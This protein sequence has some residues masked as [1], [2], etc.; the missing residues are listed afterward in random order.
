MATACAANLTRCHLHH[1][2]GGEFHRHG[3][4]DGAAFVAGCVT[5]IAADLDNE[6]AAAIRSG[7]H[8]V[9]DDGKALFIGG[10][11][12]IISRSAE[13]TRLPTLNHNRDLREGQ[14]MA[15]RLDQLAL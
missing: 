6:T 4:D 11:V 12:Q 8:L 7:S 14:Q 2:R 1:D 10:H 3:P 9:G 13:H 5:L 15:A